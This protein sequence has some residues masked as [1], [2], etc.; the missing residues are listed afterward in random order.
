MRLR[1]KLTYQG[2]DIAGSKDVYINVPNRGYVM[3]PP[4]NI[5]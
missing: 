2:R 4:K 3:I 1:G 5:L